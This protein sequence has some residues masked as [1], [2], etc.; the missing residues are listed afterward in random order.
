MSAQENKA[1]VLRLVEEFHRGNLAFVGE[2][3]FRPTS[4]SLRHRLIGTF[5]MVLKALARY[6]PLM[7]QGGVEMKIEDVVAEEDTFAVRWNLT[8]IYH[9]EPKP[10]LPKPGEKMTTGSASLFRFVNGRIDR[11]CGL[12]IVS[13]TGDPWRSK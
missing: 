12:N 10:G 11:D 3:F 1:L 2:V 4:D 13:P 7:H 8:G 6:S 9:R 5:P